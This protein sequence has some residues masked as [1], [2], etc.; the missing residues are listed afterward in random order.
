LK[1][2][3]RDTDFMLS[4][5]VQVWMAELGARG[6]GQILRT[7]NVAAKENWPEFY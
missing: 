3:I 6:G 2:P 1:E 5:T 7:D 4:F